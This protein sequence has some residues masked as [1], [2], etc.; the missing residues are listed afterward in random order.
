MY[1]CILLTGVV[2][3]FEGPD[4]EGVM[5][6][7]VLAFVIC[8]YVCM[9]ICKYFTHR[10]SSR[11]RRPRRRGGRDCSGLGVRGCS[12]DAVIIVVVVIYVCM[13]V[14]I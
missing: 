2:V 5:T 7:V 6:A 4:G 14:C 13:Y 3:G 10:S 11:I 8:M 9:H 1:V 12:R